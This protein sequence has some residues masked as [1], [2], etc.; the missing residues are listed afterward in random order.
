MNGDCSGSF[1]YIDLHIR[2]SKHSRNKVKA[3][4]ELKKD[5]KKTHKSF[6]SEVANTKQEVCQYAAVWL[7]VLFLCVY[8]ESL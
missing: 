6:Q 2:K 8:K 5:T 7:Q 4:R 1:L 3:F